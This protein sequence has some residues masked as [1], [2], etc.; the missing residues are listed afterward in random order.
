MVSKPSIKTYLQIKSENERSRHHFVISWYFITSCA[1]PQ[2]SNN[3]STSDEDTPTESE[4]FPSGT[5]YLSGLRQIQTNNS[6][7]TKTNY[8][9]ELSGY[10]YE[11]WESLGS[12]ISKLTKWGSVTMSMSYP[13]SFSQTLDRTDN[14]IMEVT[15]S[16]TGKALN[17]E[18]LD[19]GYGSVVI[20][21]TTLTDTFTSIT[22]GFKREVTTTSTDYDYELTYTYQKSSV[23][24][25][26]ND[27]STINHSIINKTKKGGI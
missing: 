10:L 12:G 22:G 5:Y 19:S 1:N 26:H 24:S 7:E 27:L 13:I 15:I 18:L 6:T 14:L 16:K 21:M 2:T 20:E 11:T 4:V 17:S 8:F 23:Y 3:S 9:W 25:R